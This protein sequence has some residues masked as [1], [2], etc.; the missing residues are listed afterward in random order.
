MSEFVQP[1]VAGCILYAEDDEND[2]FF[3]E[4][5]LNLTHSRYKL[6]SVADGEK[7]V[8]YLSGKGAFA[9]RS[10]YPLPALVLLDIN[11]PRKTGLEVL[12]WIRQQSEFKKLPVVIFTSSSRPEDMDKARR[13]DAADYLL[14]PS[15][16]RK[17][18]ELV[19][20]LH[21]RWLPQSDFQ[22]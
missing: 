2:V 21:A 9:D 14:K 8:D 1:T 4:Y 17:L 10:H 7:A 18:L 11:M 6:A 12:E 20:N 5:A 15:E 13:L 19:K 3:F 16:P 22:K